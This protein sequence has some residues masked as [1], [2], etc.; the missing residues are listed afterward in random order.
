MLS[1]L[2]SG[3]AGDEENLEE[4]QEY[5]QEKSKL[6]KRLE[7]DPSLKDDVE[8]LEGMME[9]KKRCK[10]E[11]SHLEKQVWESYSPHAFTC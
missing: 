7:R 4:K 9:E 2:F 8:T 3:A 11:L 5:D 1:G 10:Q 6:Q